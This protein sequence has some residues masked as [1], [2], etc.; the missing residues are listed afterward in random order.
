VGLDERFCG[1]KREGEKTTLAVEVS[2]SKVE[3][4]RLASNSSHTRIFYYNT[5]RRD[6][7]EIHLQH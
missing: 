7:F 5:K 2:E 6:P 1:V 3:I 4:S